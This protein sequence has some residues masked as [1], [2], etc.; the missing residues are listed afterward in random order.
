MEKI[1]QADKLVKSN[2]L[3]LEVGNPSSPVWT[4]YTK[5]AADFSDAIPAIT[6]FSLPLKTVIHEV[7]IKHSVPF[8][9]GGVTSYTLQVGISGT[10]NKYASPFDV[11]QAAGDT[12]KQVSV[13]SDLESFSGATNILIK[14]VG[15]AA[16][17][18]DAAAT[19]ALGS[20]DVWVLTSL[21]P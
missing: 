19:A 18:I 8:T 10:F 12:V 16:G 6:L 2:G 9:G 17:A 20:V 7:I 4:K 1:V 15:N 3:P 13:S 14:A 21:L 11:F 5:V